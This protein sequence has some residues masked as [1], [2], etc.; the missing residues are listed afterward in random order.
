MSRRLL[1]LAAAFWLLAGPAPAQDTASGPEGVAASPSEPVAAAVERAP[2]P[3]RESALY[4][5]ARVKAQPDQAAPLMILLHGSGQ[6]GAD[7]VAAWRDLADQQGLI[8]VG[9]DSLEPRQWSL[10]SDG[11]HFIDG[12]VQTVR[13]QHPVDLRRIYLFGY[14]GGGLYALTLALIESEYFAGV[15][16]YAALWRQDSDRAA[17]GF[18]RRQKLPVKLILGSGD[19][20]YTPE[21]HRSMEGQLRR[22]KVLVDSTVIEG[23]GHRYDNVSREVNRMA[24]AFLKDRK[25][26]GEPLYIDYGL[27][28]PPPAP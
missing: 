2:A 4:I 22:Q 6:R 20:I 28:Q 8:L 3:G 21:L 14:S 16:A 13:E 18:L 12:L 17:L 24:W 15:A 9:P 26:P 1:A 10:P 11:P 19:A 5:P 23:Q 27:D 25:L 7:L